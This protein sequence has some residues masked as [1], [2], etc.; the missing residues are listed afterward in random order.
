MWQQKSVYARKYMDVARMTFI[1]GK[2]GRIAHVFEKV[3][4][5]EHE[6]QV[7]QWLKETTYP[8]NGSCHRVTFSYFIA[9]IPQ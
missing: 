6:Q 1:I 3:K 2:N 5:A 9:T 7:L 4:P 8:G